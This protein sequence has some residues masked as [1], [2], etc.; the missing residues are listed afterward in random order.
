MC[1][2]ILGRYSNLVLCRI[3]SHQHMV[4]CPK[5][6]L[7]ETKACCL[8]WGILTNSTRDLFPSA[9]R[10]GCVCSLPVLSNLP[11]AMQRA[12]LFW[13]LLYSMG[14]S[15]SVTITWVRLQR[16][17]SH[18]RSSALPCRCISFLFLL[19]FDLESPSS[20]VTCFPICSCRWC[21][22]RSKK[23]WCP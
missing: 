23:F 17:P 16:I 9:E 14:S 15:Y 22:Q 18:W 10:N 2:S 3:F 11:T 4:S 8:L 1:Q 21:I 5:E 13:G 20:L 6:S 7:M 12:S 19:F